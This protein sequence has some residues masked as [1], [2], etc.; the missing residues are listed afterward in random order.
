MSTACLLC[1]QSNLVIVSID[2]RHL[3]RDHHVILKERS[4]LILYLVCSGDDDAWRDTIY[5]LD[6]LGV[7]AMEEN[8]IFNIDSWPVV[9]VFFA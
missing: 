9:M 6:I 7:N 5:L 2:M 4:G 8:G 3:S 1:K